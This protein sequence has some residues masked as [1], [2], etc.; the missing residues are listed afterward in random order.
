M[1]YTK[2]NDLKQKVGV[3]DIAYTLGYRLNR[4][5]GVGKYIEM[6][7]PNGRGGHSD[8]L[9]ISNPSVK[10]DQLYFHRNG[11]K[12][13][14][15]IDLILENINSFNMTGKDKWDIAHKVM[16][17]YADEPIPDYGDGKYLIEAG[18]TGNQVFDP[19]RW[20]VTPAK[21]NMHHVMSYF[22]PRGIR[23]ETV[24]AFAPFLT[25]IKDLNAKNYNNYNL[26]FPYKVPGSDEVAGYEIRGYKGFKSKAA[27]TNSSSAAWIVDMSGNDNPANIRNVYFAESGYDIMAFYQA[28]H[29]NIEKE[30]SVFVSLGGSFAD[31]QFSGIMHHYSQ[32]RAVDCCDNDLNGRI[33]GI[34]M[35]GLMDGV[36][37]N[38][39][40]TEDVI[41]LTVKGKEHLMDAPTASIQELAKFM[42]LNERIAE[43]KPAKA[44]KD[45]NDQVMNKPSAEMSLPNKFQR[46]E[47]LAENRAKGMK[48]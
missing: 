4:M 39:S 23:Q 32:A 48:L 1:G 3:D 43:W 27:G 35:A 6:S 16:A 21:G 28:N 46:N 42:T 15:V 44:F 25:R 8:T 24:E 45:W 22:E 11:S 40:R 30:C 14:D 12:G 5:A 9:V 38:I 31:Q 17:K 20:D 34:R 10:A 41:H 2:F 33:Y 13:G 29:Q 26:G 7:L 19:K 47:K 36:H 37:F 18:Y